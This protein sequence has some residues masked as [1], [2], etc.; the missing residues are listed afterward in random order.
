ML[1]ERRYGDRACNHPARRSGYCGIH[2]S[3]ANSLESADDS[4]YFEGE[5]TQRARLDYAA[6]RLRLLYVGI[7]RAKEELYLSYANRRTLFGGVSYNPPSRFLNEIPKELFHLNRAAGGRG[8]GQPYARRCVVGMVMTAGHPL[9]AGGPVPQTA[10]VLF[11]TRRCSSGPLNFATHPPE[12][13]QGDRKCR[14]ARLQRT[15]PKG[16]FQLDDMHRLPD[17]QR[18]SWRRCCLHGETSPAQTR[19][20]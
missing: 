5:A 4:R 18:V 10:A 15:G 12:D 17:R 6:E 2:D 13:S 8:R 16:L 7:T 20:D 11:V 1:R 14:S 9:E 3:A 19:H